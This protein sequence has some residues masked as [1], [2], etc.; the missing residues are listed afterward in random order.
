MVNLSKC[1]M[2]LLASTTV[3][4][5]I[6]ANTLEEAL[7][8]GKV[9]GELRSFT[10]LGS[11][12]DAPESNILDNSKA[13]ALGFQLNYETADFNGF[14]VQVGFQTAHDF[15]IGDANGA[16]TES[17][18][19]PRATAEGTNL[20]LANISYS[21]GNTNIKAGRQLIATPLMI[22][23]NTHPLRDS[24]YGLSVLNKD[25]PQ[26][27]VRFFAIKEWYQRYTAEKGNS[28]ATHFDGM[29]YS[30]YA[31]NKSITG[32]TL[33]G[34]YLTVD[35]DDNSTTKDAPV[36]VKD[37]Y[38][39]YFGSFDYK[40]PISFPLSLGALYAGAS[41]DDPK[42]DNSKF[43][44]V[45]LGTK[46][47]FLGI[48]KLA[49]TSVSDDNDFPGAMGHVPNFFRYNG[50]QMYTDNI[51]AGIDSKSILIIPNFG[52][53]KLKTLFSYAKYSQSDAGI[54]KSGHSLDGASEIQADIRY[55]FT[56]ALSVRLQSALIDY[57]D[58]KVNDDKLAISRIYLNYKF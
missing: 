9:N 27:E 20:Y 18:D 55:A 19:E 23:S 57:N 41:F 48:V 25:L 22:G 31:K 32:L 12:S 33:E 16:P 1:C 50:G 8:N 15:E 4:M 30:L 35:N 37:K 40:L 28:A 39:T 54:A 5:S 3:S 14:K 43:Y 45:K 49:Y 46:L 56:K 21:K 44:G 11:K 7:T 34:Q 51:Y 2:L 24:F 38:S 10:I 13:S 26:T 47:P 52:I 6:N 17:E 58:K 29:L 42:E 53:S 36:I